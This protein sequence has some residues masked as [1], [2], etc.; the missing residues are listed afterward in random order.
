M[1]PNG[2][3]RDMSE[4]C[5]N[6]RLVMFSFS[7]I[8]GVQTSGKLCSIARRQGIGKAYAY[9]GTRHVCRNGN[10]PFSSF[11]ICCGQSVSLLDMV[12][13]VLNTCC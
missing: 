12:E 13:T 1:I 2:H 5:R 9:R 11:N 10:R 6:G 4:S 3:E 7:G 8:P